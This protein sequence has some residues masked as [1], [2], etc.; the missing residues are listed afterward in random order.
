MEYK[1]ASSS[2]QIHPHPGGHAHCGARPD[3][4]L[5][6]TDHHRQGRRRPSQ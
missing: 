6:G 1:R 2:G 4:A 3:A 5:I